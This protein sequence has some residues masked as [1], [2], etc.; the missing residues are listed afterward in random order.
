MHNA[1]IRLEVQCSGR[2]LLQTAW[3]GE[4]RALSPIRLSA[5]G[6]RLFVMAVKHGEG[7]GFAKAANNR[8]HAHGIEI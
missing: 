3:T 4:E 6:S 5:T 8:A 1:W 2:E 7:F